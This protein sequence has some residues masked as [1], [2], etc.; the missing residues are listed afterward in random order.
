MLPDEPGTPTFV[1]VRCG[2]ALN[3]RDADEDPQ[4]DQGRPIC[5]ECARER[6]FIDFEVAMQET[7]HD[8]EV[9]G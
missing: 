7:S 6:D 5:G 4:G 8:D 1:C 2:R 9:D 3:G